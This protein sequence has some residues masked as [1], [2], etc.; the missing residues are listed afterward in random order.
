MGEEVPV[1][2]HRAVPVPLAG[3]PFQAAHRL[4]VQ[5]PQPLQ[6]G[7]TPGRVR[8]AAGSAVR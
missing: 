6:R 8:I 1:G 5:H 3:L 7:L 4:Q 2:R